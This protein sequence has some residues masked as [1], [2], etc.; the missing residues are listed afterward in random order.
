MEC[1]TRYQCSQCDEIHEDEDDAREC[2]QPEVWEVYECG[3]CGKLHGSS[4]V[5]AKSCCEQLVKCPACS[6]DYGQ[7]N[8]ASHS[9][10]V[11]GHCPACNPLFTVD[12][13][14]KIEDLHYI[15]TGTNASI[16][17]GGW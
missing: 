7:H 12:E 15:R 1:K 13:Q 10:E 9:I 16:L 11:A 3:E 4:E 14:F 2:C 5:A 17:Q 6:R 8:I